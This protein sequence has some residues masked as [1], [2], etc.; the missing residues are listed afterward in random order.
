MSDLHSPSHS[1]HARVF[2][3]LQQTQRAND[4]IDRI[5]IRTVQDVDETVAMRLRETAIYSLRH[6]V[7]RA[8]PDGLNRPARRET[9]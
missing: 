9:L 1:R 2:E 8:S 5:K 7:Y 3:L 4:T 6:P